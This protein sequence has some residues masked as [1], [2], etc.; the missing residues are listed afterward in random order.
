MSASTM[1]PASRDVNMLFALRAL[2]EEL[3][4][5]RAAERMGVGQPAMSG[6]LS[7][8]RTHYGDE[9]LV[10]FGRDYEP[11]PL[12]R[13]LLPHVQEATA[14]IERLL[15]ASPRV[16][17]P[18][19]SARSFTIFTAGYGAHLLHTVLS[20]VVQRAPAIR[21]DVING[22]TVPTEPQRLWLDHDLVLASTVGL[23]ECRSALIFQDRFVCVV[24]REHP[25]S[26]RG[27]MEWPDFI[28]AEFVLGECGADID[29]RLRQALLRRGH[30]IH[31]R[32]EVESPATALHLVADT[33][34][35]AIA[36]ER[37]AQ[38][39]PWTDRITVL[40]PPFGEVPIAHYLSWHA[41]RD[42]DPGLQWMIAQLRE[43]AGAG[44]P[45]PNAQDGSSGL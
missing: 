45:D 42:A 9:L 36:P 40:E 11:T 41:I 20:P 5:T 12:A 1:L 31:P 27:A 16:F 21:V 25:L 29:G 26:R 22:Q 17:D 44:E 8:L 23:P 28:E 3:N 43:R 14:S 19:Q 30:E 13:A 38:D 7:R 2:L 37:L 35:V 10:R 15:G 34:L 33:D 32:V 24:G 39:G 4:V 6:I 18:A